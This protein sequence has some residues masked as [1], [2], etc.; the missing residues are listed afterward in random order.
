[1][2][3]KVCLLHDFFGMNGIPATQDKKLFMWDLRAPHAQ[4]AM[5][6]PGQPY[7][8][9]DEEGLVFAAS[10]GS[11]VSLFDARSYEHGP[12]LSFPVP[13]KQHGMTDL[14]SVSSMKFSCNQQHLMT[15]L[16]GRVFLMDTFS[17]R[18]IVH[19]NTGATDAALPM[20]ASFSADGNAILSGLPLHTAIIL[21]RV[22]ISVMWLTCR[23]RRQALVRVELSTAR[24]A[25]VR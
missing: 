25:A 17:G 1:M 19:W 18:E 3:G 20:E 13:V 21:C 12:F 11:I 23:R 24:G 7:C 14:A 16:G 22:D 2:I 9:M 4:A 15:V 5:D 6:V 10:A 8:V